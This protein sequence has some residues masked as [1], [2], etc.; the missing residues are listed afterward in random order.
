MA[1]SQADSSLKNILR[2]TGEQSKAASIE[3]ALAAL[4]RTLEEAPLKNREHSAQLRIAVDQA[5]AGMAE[6]SRKLD[7]PMTLGPVISILH[8]C[9]LVSDQNPPRTMTLPA[10]QGIIIE[11][12]L[13][14]EHQRNVINRLIEDDLRRL[15]TPQSSKAIR[16]AFSFYTSEALAQEIRAVRT[17]IDKIGKAVKDFQKVKDGVELE[18]SDS[19]FPAELSGLLEDISQSHGRLALW[20]GDLTRISDRKPAVLKGLSRQHPPLDILDNG[21]RIIA[22]AARIQEIGETEAARIQAALL[23][24]CERGIKAFS[25]D[26][27]GAIAS[28]EHLLQEARKRE[29]AAVPPPVLQ[30]ES[31]PRPKPG[32]KL[33]NPQ[34]LEALR[35][36]F[37]DAPHVIEALAGLSAQALSRLQHDFVNAG[38]KPSVL[39]FLIEAH[40]G[41]MRMSRKQRCQLV[42]ETAEL[43]ARLNGRGRR[44][45]EFTS[46]EEARKADRQA[47]GEGTAVVIE[48][49]EFFQR[50][51]QI[52]G[53]AMQRAAQASGL[54]G[55]RFDPEYAAQAL[56][57]GFTFSG[58]YHDSCSHR[59]SPR[60]MRANLERFLGS[61][62]VPEALFQLRLLQRVGLIEQNKGFWV[63]HPGKDSPWAEVA[64]VLK[65]FKTL[66]KKPAAGEDA[67]V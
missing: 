34:S 6:A 46:L 48:R 3:S 53:K 31:F 5:F 67:L 41:F 29:S 20:A 15:G 52:L 1:L 60:S 57:Y 33:R 19:G 40:S 18:L 30:G 45:S 63:S 7:S 8:F 54:P 59:M 25:L 44:L 55:E 23:E 4:R 38:L 27:S 51:I 10:K 47:R 39:G 12:C 65:E 2:N 11:A 36:T 37:G 35:A 32:R 49:D 22:A 50:H 26:C 43:K 66:L 61:E 56:I 24:A 13:V 42:A 9:E 58:E 28:L 62:A 17:A 64:R 16:R 21:G 14:A